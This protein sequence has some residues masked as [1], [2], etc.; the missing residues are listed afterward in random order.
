MALTNPI[1]EVPDS[2][3]YNAIGCQQATFLIIPG[4][5]DY[6]TG[7]YVI[8]GL[9]LRMPK[10]IVSVSIDGIN[11]TGNNLGFLFTAVVNY[12]LSSNGIPIV[13]TSFNIFGANIVTSV[14]TQLANNTNLA[15]MILSITVQGY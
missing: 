3:Q 10:G 11:T 5:N 8:S 13:P 9:Q 15:G 14:V 4:T 2:R 12:T 6:P 1:P 7:G